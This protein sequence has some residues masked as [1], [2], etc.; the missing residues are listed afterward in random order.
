MK[1]EWNKVTGYSKFFA[2]ILFITT[3]CLAFWL[4]GEYKEVKK[5]IRES[6]APGSAEL[7]KND[8]YEN[9]SNEYSIVDALNWKTYRNNE[10]G[11]AIKYPPN[12]KIMNTIEG[13]PI[14]A[15]APN[16]YSSRDGTDS[17][18]GFFSISIFGNNLTPEF[19]TELLKKPL[20]S[21]WNEGDFG[22]DRQFITSDHKLSIYMIGGENIELRL[23][24]DGMLESFQLLN[25]RD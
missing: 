20:D 1:I 23:I 18:Y 4:V 2:V 16:D 7:N 6:S 19:K 3:F 17:P 15:F 22:T 12:W 24:E 10:F 13:G 11:F 14:V 25:A 9:S 8:P 5:I 21:G